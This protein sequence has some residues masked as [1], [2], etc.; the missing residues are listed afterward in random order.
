MWHADLASHKAG[1]RLVQ[2]AGESVTVEMQVLDTMLNGYGIC[3][4]G[5]LFMLADTAFALACNNS[6]ERA[7]SA[8]ATIDY[9]IPAETGDL[10]VATAKR[11]AQK[12]RAGLFDVTICCRGEVIA[13]FRGRS[14]RL[15][16]PS[17]SAQ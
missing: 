15:T 1:V 13:E 5:L 6:G 14:R 4:G 12:G 17:T 7:V 3:H 9:L 10:L 2:A 16:R 8:G 11:R